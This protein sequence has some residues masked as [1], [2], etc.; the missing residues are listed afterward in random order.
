MEFQP[1]GDSGSVL[2]VV[3]VAKAGG[4]VGLVGRDEDVLTITIEVY[5]ILDLAWNEARVV[6]D[7]DGEVV[8]WDTIILQLVHREVVEGGFSWCG[9]VWW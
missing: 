7:V 3:Q 9:G 5:G 2:A 6:E 4:V 1:H 8:V